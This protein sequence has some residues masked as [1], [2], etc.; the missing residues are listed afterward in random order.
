MNKPTCHIAILSL[1]VLAGLG[2]STPAGGQSRPPALAPLPT[3]AQLRHQRYETIMFIHFGPNTFTNKEWGWY[4]SPWDRRDER[5]TT[6]AYNDYF[7]NQIKEL[8]TEYGPVVEY[9]FDGAHGPGVSG[10]GKMAPYDWMRIFNT[11]YRYQ[12]DTLISMM[13]PDIGWA[14]NE[15]ATGP[16]TNWNLVETPHAVPSGMRPGWFDIAYLGHQL[17]DAVEPGEPNYKA[18]PTWRYIHKECNTSI[19]PSW[20]WHEGTRAKPLDLLMGTYFQSVGRGGVFLLN[21]TPDNTGRFPEDQVQ[22]LREFRTTVDTIFGANL[23]DK[24][25]A[26]ASATWE[27][28]NEFGPAATIDGDLHTYWA[29]ERFA[30]SG[31]ITC[32]LGSPRQFNV[33]RMQEPV[34]RGQRVARYRVERLDPQTGEWVVLSRGT[35]IGHKK[36]DRVPTVTTRQVRL[37]IEDARSCPLIAELG[38][39]FDP[40]RKHAMPKPAAPPAEAAGRIG[41]ARRFVDDALSVAHD[42]KLDPKTLT[43]IAWVNMDAFPPAGVDQRR[44]VVNKNGDEYKDTY[45][46]LLLNHRGAGAYVNIGGGKENCH[47]A[48]SDEDIL[49]KGKW[50]Q[51]AM[52]YDGTRLSLYIDGEPTARTTIGKPRT[53]GDGAMVIGQRADKLRRNF[54]G[55]IDEVRFYDRAL[56]PGEIKALFAAPDSDE[57]HE[58]L[59]QFW[60]F[61]D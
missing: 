23:L 17:K 11:I 34:Q 58:G 1:A 38:L 14:R 51:L 40:R 46:G 19:I 24:A 35:T 47:R 36:L 26:T 57:A 60:R 52:T 8:S 22:R 10:K 54:N 42:P 49:K 45:F 4:L 53:P 41:K 20:F 27:D 21:L 61:D 39:H 31:T 7:C 29:A 43:M 32:D 37:V 59:Q 48:F 18:V 33:I 56:Q 9:W 44:W 3:E 16:E 13:G 50:H 30:T 2:A 25:S 55:S 12:A 28:S 6:E 15:R 5:Y